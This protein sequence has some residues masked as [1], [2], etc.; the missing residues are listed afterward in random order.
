MNAIRQRRYSGKVQRMTLAA[1]V[2]AL[3]HWEM[4]MAICTKSTAVC[5]A[6]SPLRVG[7]RCC[8]RPPLLGMLAAI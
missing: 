1:S 7:G 6:M 4:A 2:C 5:A 3:P 8:Q